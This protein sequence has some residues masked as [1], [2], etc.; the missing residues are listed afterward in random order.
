MV[1]TGTMTR[2]QWLVSKSIECAGFFIFNFLD[3]KWESFR[4]TVREKS[5][6]NEVSIK[7]S[8]RCNRITLLCDKI[9]YS[10]PHMTGTGG[11][12]N[13]ARVQSLFLT[14]VEMKYLYGAMFLIRK[15][16]WK[17]CKRPGKSEGSFL[18]GSFPE[19]KLDPRTLKICMMKW[20][21]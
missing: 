3:S 20:T 7:A 12:K 21:F 17:Y 2:M 14:S 6:C 4:F 1:S 5:F 8:F 16:S 18:T 10:V 9:A 15:I 13:W 19:K 11:I